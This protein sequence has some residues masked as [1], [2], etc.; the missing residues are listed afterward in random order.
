MDKNIDNTF[1]NIETKENNIHTDDLNK[2]MNS[3]GVKNKIQ[4]S[5]IKLRT[6]QKEKMDELQK[7]R[8]ETNKYNLIDEALDL[9]EEQE[10]LKAFDNE[11]IINRIN[12][13]LEV[14]AEGFKIIDTNNKEIMRSKLVQAQEIMNRYAKEKEEALNELENMTNSVNEY[15]SDIETLSS[16]LKDKENELQEQI[17]WRL[18]SEKRLELIEEEKE[19]L[20]EEL[21][22]KNDTVSDYIKEVQGLRETVKRITEQRDN[23]ENLALK[24]EKDIDKKVENEVQLRLETVKCE[25]NYKDQDISKKENEIKNLNA[26][27]VQ[28][29]LDHQTQIVLKDATIKGLE[30]QI[31]SLKEMHK[32][33]IA[34]IRENQNK[35]LQEMLNSYKQV[36]AQGPKE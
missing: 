23:L 3:N 20:K 15:K 1:E 7:T 9:V 22:N 24:L 21:N 34:Q 4:T 19:K 28:K 12:G 25:L 30:E 14:I 11:L 33:D 5:T 17:A 8:G 31:V 13:A 26:E 6:D 32:A 29:D 10:R 16:T 35:I 27:L 2:D 18:K 36:Q